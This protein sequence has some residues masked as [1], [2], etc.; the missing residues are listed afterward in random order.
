MED[1]IL[2]IQS[3]YVKEMLKKFR[4]EDSKQTKTPMSMEIKLTKD[5]DANSVD[6]SKYQDILRNPSEEKGKKNASLLVISSSS[7]S[8]DNNEAPSFLEFYD[9]LSD[10]EDLTKAQREK[11]GMF[12]CLDRYVSTITKYLVKQK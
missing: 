9:E 6:S 12:K 11:G 10:S 3:K 5:D 2:F 1:G 4:L 8:F 7:S